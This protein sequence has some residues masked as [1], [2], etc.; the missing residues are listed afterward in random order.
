[1]I[2][3][4]KIIYLILIII[5]VVLAY[6]LGTNSKSNTSFTNHAP[7]GEAGLCTRTTPYANPPEL[8][9]ALD[10]AVGK[11][12][13]ATDAPQP[14][15]GSF[16]NCIHLIYKPHNEMNGLEGFF[17][18]DKNSDANDI[19][20]YIDDTYKNYDDILTASLLVHE[21]RHAT[22]FVKALEGT[23]APSCVQD[24]VMAFYSQII[25]LNNLNPEEWKSITLRLAQNPHLNSAYE[26]TNSLLMINK[27]A[28]NSCQNDT[29]QSCW[30]TY[31]TDHLKSWV[32]ANPYYQKQ[33]NL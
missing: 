10:L 15:K 28:T 23:P 33:C 12:I 9:R 2:L 25:Y 29:T 16:T 21:L 26:L 27:D 6:K 7:T 22:N 19:R 11:D 17:S 24:E 32:E 3:K 13:G 14:P 20:I 4:N 1:M 8:L 31:I 18:F 30:N 5:L